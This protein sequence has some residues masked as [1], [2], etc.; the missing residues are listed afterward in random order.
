MIQ[1]PK[2]TFLGRQNGG[3]SAD[4]TAPFLTAEVNAVWNRV[5]LISQPWCE[6]VET[7]VSGSVSSQ[8]E[9]KAYAYRL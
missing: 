9:E 2:E 4:Q 6:S 1:V 5:L 8:G 7:E 3:A